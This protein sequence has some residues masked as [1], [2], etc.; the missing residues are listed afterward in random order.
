MLFRSALAD[1]VGKTNAIANIPKG[2]SPTG[3]YVFRV[4]YTTGLVVIPGAG[5]VVAVTYSATA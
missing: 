5:Q 1:T 2:H 4:F 3:N